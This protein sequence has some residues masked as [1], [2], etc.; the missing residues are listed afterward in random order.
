MKKIKFNKEARKSLKKG[1]DTLAQAV[2][3]TLGPKGRN[4]VLDRGYASPLI[5]NDGVTIA[6][7]IE[8]EDEIENMGAELIKEVSI[9]SNDVA[10]DGTTTATV[11]A[12]S[13]I[14][15]GLELIDKGHN[16]VLIQ[17]G[18]QK[19]LH[20]SLE[21]L[22]KRAIQI[23]TDKE[24]QQIASISASNEEIGNLI[25]EAIKKVGRQG[26][27]TV[28]EAN[29]IDTSLEIVEG[30]QFSNGYLSP[31]MVTNN[32]RMYAELNNPFILI[33]DKTINSMK[34]L[35]PILEQIME[36]NRPILIIA[37]NVEGE[38]LTTLVLNKIRSTL[39]VVAVKAPSYG[40]RRIALL[41]D[42][43]ILTGG[44][45]ITEQKGLT[46]ENMKLHQLGQARKVKITKDSTTIVDGYGQEKEIKDRILELKSLKSIQ[47]TSYDK[48]K[49][50]ERIA[51]LSQGIAVI[52]VGANTELEMKEKK[53]RIEDAINA[54]K[55]AIEEGIVSGG[56]SILLQIAKDIEFVKVNEDEKPGFE[57]VRKAFLE[58]TKQIALNS[59]VN[60]EEIIEKIYELGDGMG[61]NANSEKFVNMIQEGIIDPAKVTRSAIQSSISI[62]SL[63]LTTEVAIAK[64]KDQDKEQQGMY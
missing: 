38:A 51:K 61:Y 3:V 19:A 31:Y 12:S 49:I 63:I 35:V 46:I 4:V 39:E 62:S 14:N 25:S 59:G 11:L 41:E 54:T 26:V 13:M 23:S 2:K 16:P 6:R 20:Y 56:G 24:I 43:A 64:I 50:D 48:E 33:T 40:D 29:S 34:E 37:T 28:E 17:K 21:H 58:P 5:T 7:E 42:I 32:E 47:S 27:L 18:M 30:M 44:E 57:V 1:I 45:L 22:K 55:S 8:L 10:G 53:L 9:K 36:K 60:G 52:R 15:Y